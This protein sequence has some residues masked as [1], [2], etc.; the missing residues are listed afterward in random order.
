M[1][2]V[3]RGA[4]SSSVAR[5]V[6]LRSARAP[7]G[8]G[9]GRPE[10]AAGPSFDGGVVGEPA[11]PG[12]CVRDTEGVWPYG[13]SHGTAGRLSGVQPASVARGVEMSMAASRGD[14]G[15]EAFGGWAVVRA[16]SCAG[17]ARGGAGFLFP[18]EGQSVGS[19]QRGL[20]V[21]GVRV[22][23]L[24]ELYERRYHDG[25]RMWGSTHAI[26]NLVEAI[27]RF[28]RCYGYQGAVV[29]ADVSGRGGG[30]FL[31]HRSHQ[32]GR[33]VDIWL[34]ARSGDYEGAPGRRVRRPYADEVDWEATWS[35]V[36]ALLATG[37]IEHIFL[38]YELQARL[39][40]IARARGSSPE[41]LAGILQ[42]PRSSSASGIVAHADGHRRHMHVRF[43]CGADEERCDSARGAL[44][45]MPRIVGRDARGRGMAAERVGIRSGAK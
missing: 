4:A 10:E 38:E 44:E 23:E 45:V 21:G 15:A 14:A 13:V 12:S 8:G 43:T 17:A 39:H 6:S 5:G 11:R 22:P 31:P 42:Y 33:D 19:P 34:L 36:E 7:R 26:G 41:R 18:G 37:A 30:E 2:F 29:V 32:S 27:A 40:V 3:A 20:L 35:L 25:Q 1:S 9:A 28:R 16:S 24:P